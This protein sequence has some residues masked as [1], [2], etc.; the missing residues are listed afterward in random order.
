MSTVTVKEPVSC[1][2]SWIA[3]EF[4]NLEL[5]TQ[6]H[7][8]LRFRAQA[9]R[10]GPSLWPQGFWSSGIPGVAAAGGLNGPSPTFTLPFL[11][12]ETT[13][14][15]QVALDS[16][17]VDGLAT[18][19]FSTPDLSEVGLMPLSPGD[20]TLGLRMS[21][22][23]S[24]GRVDGYLVQWK[25]GDEEYDDMGTLERQRTCPA[26]GTGSTPSPGWTTA[27]STPCGR[28]PTTTTASVCRP[29]RSRSRRRPSQQSGHGSAHHQRRRP[30]GR[31]PDG[32]TADIEDADGLDNAVYIYQWLAMAPT[33]PG[34]RAQATRWWRP[35]RG[36]PSG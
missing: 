29:G 19:T 6:Y 36:R 20:G 11:D 31:D 26:P 8:H 21:E 9:P 4:A 5:A 24:D 18:T 16:G 10:A 34:Q 33:Y 14:E 13:Y 28:W 7:A 17:F 15:V 32:G 35:T 23:T 22:P 2:V 30:G 1:T 25:S 3:L 27:S 12:Y